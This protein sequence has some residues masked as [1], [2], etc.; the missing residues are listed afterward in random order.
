MQKASVH[1][2]MLMF[3][4]RITYMLWMKKKVNTCHISKSSVHGMG[5]L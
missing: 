2:E 4:W 3:A 1:Y 5:K